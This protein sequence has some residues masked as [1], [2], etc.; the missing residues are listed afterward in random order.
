MA[1][2]ATAER[3]PF[4]C[5]NLMRSNLARSNT[6]SGGLAQSSLKMDCFFAMIKHFSAVGAR[7]LRLVCK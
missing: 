7:W 2:A 6:A 5:P 1:N 3:K 4:T